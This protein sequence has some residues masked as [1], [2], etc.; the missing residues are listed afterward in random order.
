MDWAEE[1]RVCQGGA[2]VAPWHLPPCQ[3]L[4]REGVG[5]RERERAWP[6][7]EDAHAEGRSQ[8]QT[9]RV[10][11]RPDLTPEHPADLSNWG[12]PGLRPPFSS[13]LLLSAGPWSSPRLPSALPGQCRVGGSERTPAGTRRAQP[14]SISPPPGPALLS[15]SWSWSFGEVTQMLG[16]GDSTAGLRAHS[17]LPGR[18]EVQSGMQDSG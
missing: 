13:Q 17:P 8:P 16:R 7:L 4:G 12:I 15:R 3:A 1:A 18:T 6:C 14:P 5:S 9:H 11:A 2:E 10:I